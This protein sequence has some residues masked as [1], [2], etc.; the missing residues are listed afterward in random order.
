MFQQ[1]LAPVLNFTF[2]VTPRKLISYS[3]LQQLD[4]VVR[5]GIRELLGIGRD[6]PNDFL[7]SRRTDGGLAIVKYK[8]EARVQRIQALCLL[9]Q[10]TDQSAIHLKA[11]YICQ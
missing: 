9:H 8:W 11:N 5:N 2:Q 7:Y 1:Y 4:L 6:V 3:W 10:K